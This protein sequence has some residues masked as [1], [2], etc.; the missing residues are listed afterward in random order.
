MHQVERHADPR[1]DDRANAG[2][3][4]PVDVLLE[5]RETTDRTTQVVLHLKIGGLVIPK[6]V[7]D[8]RGLRGDVLKALV[9]ILPKVTMRALHLL[10]HVREE[11]LD[12]E[13]HHR[14][15]YALALPWCASH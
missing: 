4:K 6:G 5:V 1:N 14:D 13:G 12:V 9:H 3:G 11:L 7:R 8:S 2:P 10:P 15:A